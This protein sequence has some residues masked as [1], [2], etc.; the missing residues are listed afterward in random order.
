MCGNWHECEGKAVRQTGRS[1]KADTSW[2]RGLPRRYERLPTLLTKC[3][4]E[5]N[6]AIKHEMV[7]L[8][9]HTRFI[10]IVKCCYR[11]GKLGSLIEAKTKYLPT[12]KILKCGIVVKVF[13]CNHCNILAC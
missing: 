4:F 6:F 9:I 5:F 12:F 1:I 7:L 13:L 3:S 2:V 8:E 11:K 10:L